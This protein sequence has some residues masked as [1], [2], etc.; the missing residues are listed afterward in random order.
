ME[1]KRVA[2]S[3]LCTIGSQAVLLTKKNEIDEINIEA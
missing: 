3:L 2:H 1:I